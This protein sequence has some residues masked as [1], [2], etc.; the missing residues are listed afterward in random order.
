MSFVTRHIILMEG[1]I[2]RWVHCQNRQHFSDLP[3]S[4]FGEPMS[5]VA[6]ILC[7]WQMKVAAIVVVCFCRRFAPKFD[8]LRVQRRS[9]AFL[10]YNKWLFVIFL[11]AGS[12]L[13]IFLRLLGSTRYFPT[14]N[15][16]PLNIL[17]YVEHFL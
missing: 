8:M 7:L 12:S 9:S 6:P 17:S 15:C 11:S 2:R 1:E 5:T 13:A 16:R 4:H 3:L 10:G 14:E